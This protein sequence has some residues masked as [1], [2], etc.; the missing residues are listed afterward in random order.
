MNDTLIIRLDEEMNTGIAL[1]D[2]KQKAE[3]DRDDLGP[4]D[5]AAVCIPSWGEYPRVPFSIKNDADAP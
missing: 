1:M 5:V 4:S 2:C 3:F